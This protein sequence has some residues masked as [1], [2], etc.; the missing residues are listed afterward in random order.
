M[1]SLIKISWNLKD[2]ILLINTIVDTSLK[3]KN[4]IITLFGVKLGDISFFG[5][6]TITIFLLKKKKNIYKRNFFTCLK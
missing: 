1:I 3:K 2:F 5:G 4:L 6:L